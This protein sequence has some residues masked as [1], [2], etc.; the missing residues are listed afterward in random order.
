[1]DAAYEFGRAFPMM[2]T[3]AGTVPPARVFIMGVGVAGLQ[4][5]ATA[6][7]LGAIVSATDVRPATKEQVES[8]GASFVAVEDEEFQQAQTEGGYAKEMSDAY[9]TKQAALIAET[10]AKQDIVICTALI[11]GRTAPRLVT[12]DMLKSMKPGAVVVDLA[13]EAGGNCAGSVAGKIVTKHGVKIVGHYNVPGR[14]AEDASKLF[15][16]NLLS[17]LT[18]MIDK[19]SKSLKIDMADEIVAGTLIARDGAVVH[20]KLAGAATAPEKNAETATKGD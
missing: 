18:P 6:K 14:I 12:E 5:I 11:P 9:K 7:R 1:L 17:F 3:A 19:D 10:I 16:R 4:A 15:A 2:M 8:L 13:V 20:P